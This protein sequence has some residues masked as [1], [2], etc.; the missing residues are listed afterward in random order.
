MS[1][2]KIII[3][4]LNQLIEEETARMEEWQEEYPQPEN[5]NNMC[6]EC[7]FET[8]DI[9]FSSKE[10]LCFLEGEKDKLC[11]NDIPDMQK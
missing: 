3:N 10:V 7:G 5:Q 4:Y 6:Y 9:A 2:K 1:N 11:K 8:H